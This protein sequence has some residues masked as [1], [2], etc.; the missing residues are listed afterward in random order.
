MKRCLVQQTKTDHTGLALR[1]LL[2]G[3]WA[4]IGALAWKPGER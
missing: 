3:D 4:G 2:L 1:N